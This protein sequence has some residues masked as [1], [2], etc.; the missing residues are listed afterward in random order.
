MCQKEAT[1]QHPHTHTEPHLLKLIKSSKVNHVEIR[2]MISS[3]ISYQNIII[4]KSTSI[5]PVNLDIKVSVILL[6]AAPN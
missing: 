4:N 5:I 2:E 1:V 3:C 6:D